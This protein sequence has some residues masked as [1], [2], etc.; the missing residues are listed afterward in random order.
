M[1]RARVIIDASLNTLPFSQPKDSGTDAGGL[2]PPPLPGTDLS[3]VEESSAPAED[4][5]EA[6]IEYVAPPPSREIPRWL[7]KLARQL[8]LLALVVALSAVSY[9]AMSR[10]IVTGVVIEGKSMTPTLHEGDR[11][12]LNRWA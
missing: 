10:L 5:S 4:T 1:R 7:A 12:L 11:Y 2:R 6:Q 3:P 8:C 9:V